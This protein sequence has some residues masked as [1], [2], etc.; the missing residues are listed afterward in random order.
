VSD[1]TAMAGFTTAGR[2]DR[3]LPEMVA[4]GVDVVLGTVDVAADFAALVEAVDI[5]TEDRLDEAVRRVLATKASLGLHLS[6]FVEGFG[7]PAF[8]HP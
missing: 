8:D 5:L 6:P 3:T 1:N 2:R 4:A 7:E